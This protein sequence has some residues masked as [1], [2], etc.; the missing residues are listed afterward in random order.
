MREYIVFNTQKRKE[1]TS[2]F[3]KD[4]YKLMNLSVFGKVSNKL[5]LVTLLI[6]IPMFMS[7]RLSFI[8]D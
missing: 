7:T 4:F 6:L 8:L 2:N 5:A 3:T 1:A